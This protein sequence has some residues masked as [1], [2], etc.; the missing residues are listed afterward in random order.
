MKTPM[1]ESQQLISITESDLTN[2]ALTSERWEDFCRLFGARGACSGC[3]CMHWR[4]SKRE[5]DANRG[6][7]NRSAMKLLVDAKHPVGILICHGSEAIGWCAIAPR[8]AFSTLQRSRIFAPID[9]QL[10]W[11]IVCFFITKAY[12]GKGVSSK[13]IVAAV[14][15]AKSH[16][17][18]IVEAYPNDY[19]TALPAPFVFS[20]LL[21]AFTRVGFV[22][23]ARRSNHR[24]IVRYLIE[25]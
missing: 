22:E 13:L 12:R 15:Y 14:D 7:N 11:S 16:G 1:T 25:K 5:F 17:A 18:K 23:V 20:G 19:T 3:W 6:D 4:L 8:E 21:P 10:V 24:P 9:D 2:H